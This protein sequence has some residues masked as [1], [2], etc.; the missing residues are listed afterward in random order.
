MPSMYPSLAKTGK[1]KSKNLLLCSRLELLTFAL[2]K[3]NY[4]YD[5]LTDCANRAHW[6]GRLRPVVGHC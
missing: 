1:N 6:L 3:L 2:L 5:A 4:K